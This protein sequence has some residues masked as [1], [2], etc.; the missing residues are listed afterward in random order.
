MSTPS[1]DTPV[2]E[3]GWCLQ[4][5]RSGDGGKSWE[6][7]A[8]I[9]GIFDGPFLAADCG[10]GKYQGRLY[11]STEAGVLVS[12]DKGKSFG[13]ARSLPVSPKYRFVTGWPVVLSDGT[14]V[15][16]SEAR[17]RKEAPKGQVGSPAPS[18]LSARSS[19]DGG[20]SYADETLV[21]QSQ[22]TGREVNLPMAAFDPG[23]K[24]RKDHV[25]T[26]WLDKTPGG[27]TCV[28]FARSTDKGRTF[29]APVAVSE[30]GAWRGEHD[31]SLPCVAVNKDGVV[32]V[33]WYDT[34]DLGPKEVRWDVRF[35]ASTDGGDTWTPSVRVTDYSRPGGGR[36]KPGPWSPGHTAGLAAGADNVFHVLWIDARTGVE[37]AWIAAVEV[38]AR[39]KVPR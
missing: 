23:S 11:C 6:K 31:A 24:D 2:R 33:S 12:A 13:N 36:R 22:M 27:R 26:V 16:V 21:A 28:L 3:P 35:R 20:E 1:L 8:E 38:G 34:R 5:A 30:A 18:Y 17:L 39:A 14:L 15:V 4:V 32:G 7:P 29:S 25:Y 10:T 9:Q 37:Q 19:S